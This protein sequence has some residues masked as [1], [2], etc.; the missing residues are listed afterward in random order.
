MLKIDAKASSSMADDLDRGR[1]TEID[2]LCGEVIRLGQRVGR[3]APLNKRMQELVQAWPQHP[4]RL[5]PGEMAQAL[6]LD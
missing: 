3:P 4:Q 2:A 6:G 1:V 5:Y